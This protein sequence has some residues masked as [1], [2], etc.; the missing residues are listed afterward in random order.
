MAGISWVI[1]AEGTVGSVERTA[2]LFMMPAVCLS[3]VFSVWRQNCQELHS[4]SLFSIIRT[5]MASLCLYLKMNRRVHLLVTLT[6]GM[7][8]IKEEHCVGWNQISPSPITDGSVLSL[9]WHVDHFADLNLSI[10]MQTSALKAVITSMLSCSN[11]RLSSMSMRRGLDVDV[12]VCVYTHVVKIFLLCAA[13]ASSYS[14]WGS[15]VTQK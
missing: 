3:V 5:L 10:N 9:S 4:T 14:S 15:K 6:A 12:C 7:S 8:E 2:S 1:L 13:S 11:V